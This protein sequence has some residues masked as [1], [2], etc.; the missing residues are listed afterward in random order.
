MGQW[1]GGET[2][3][4][5]V[6]QVLESVIDAEEEKLD[7]QIHDLERMDEDDFEKLPQ[8]R[9][10]KMKKAQE[11]RRKWRAQGHGDYTRISDQKEFFD[12]SK[13]SKCVIVHLGRDATERCKIVDM[14]ME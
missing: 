6:A 1:D 9:L 12:A 8:Q 5:M 3:G 7:D 11:M 14:H 4:A 2:T 10:E 13:T